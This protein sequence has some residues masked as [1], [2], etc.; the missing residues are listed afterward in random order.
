MKIGIDIDE[1]LVE[2][3][4]EIDKYI[5]KYNPGLTY[6]NEKY[7]TDKEVNAFLLKHIYDMQQNAELKS[8]AK[9][10]LHKLK[11]KGCKIIIITARGGVID[12][13]YK[14]VTEEYFKKHNLPYDKIYCGQSDKGKVAKAENLDLFIDDKIYNLDNVTKQGIESLQFASNL[15]QDSKYKKFNNWDDILKYIVTKGKLE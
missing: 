11:E 6:E 2:T 10:V 14:K 15:K 9:E 8:G 7:L 1:T 12:Y 4:K 5:K 13:D 3:Y